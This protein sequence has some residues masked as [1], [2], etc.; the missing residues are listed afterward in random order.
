MNENILEVFLLIRSAFFAFKGGKA[1]DAFI[2]VE[3][4]SCPV[5]NKQ[6]LIISSLPNS[7]MDIDNNEQGNHFEQLKYLND[8]I[9][10]QSNL[11]TNM[12]IVRVFSAEKRIA[13]FKSN[14]GRNI[15]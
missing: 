13:L 6:I 4:T 12:Q 8:P 1:I 9:L 7:I 11:E 2:A 10:I 15:I 5:K 14:F 3:L